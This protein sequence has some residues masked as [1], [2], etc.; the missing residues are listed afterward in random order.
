MN[1]NETSIV[2]TGDIG[3]DRYMEGKW[4]DQTLLSKEILDFLHSG[5]HVLANVEGALIAQEEAEDVNNKGLFFHTM[6]PDATKLLDSGRY[7]EFRQ[8]P[9]HG[10]R[11]RWN[12]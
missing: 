8:Q 10:R 11:C 9:C 5:D 7:L 4:E 12:H 6:N 2:F 3:F 1:K